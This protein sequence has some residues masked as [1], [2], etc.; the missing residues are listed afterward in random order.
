M[1]NI[2]ALLIGINNYPVKPL[3]GCINDVAAMKACLEKLYENLP[4]SRLHIKHL[5]D[6]GEEQPTRANIIKAFDFFQVA[7]PGDECLFYFSGHGS[8]TVA[9]LIFQSSSNELQSLVCIDSRSPGGLDLMDKELGFLIW[10]TTQTNKG[11]FF[12][13]I[14]DCC[15]SGT[16]TKSLQGIGGVT[17]RLL[18]GSLAHIPVNI[19]NYLGYGTQIDGIEAYDITE[20]CGQPYVRTATGNHYHLS[21][22]RD[23]Q[24]AKE[25]PINQGAVQ[26]AFTHCLIQRLYGNGGL[27][28]Y[29][30]LIDD[31]TVFVKNRVS[32]QSPSLNTYGGEGLSE[33][34]TFMGQST[35]APATAFELS[36]STKNGE[37]WNINGGALHGIH[38]GDEI[39]TSSGIRS[40]VVSAIGPE[41][42]AVRPDLAFGA[43]GQVYPVSI[44]RK[45]DERY[46]VSI[47]SGTG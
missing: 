45:A 32:E 27:V 40:T 42:S 20:R 7:K 15:H 17:E 23:Y 41:R 1:A 19:E 3:S 39:L 31:T 13:A 25:L 22:S 47:R 21:A 30:K 16:I 28:S 11:I 38:P 5:T 24:T 6:E 14:T 37:G 36:Y 33:Q 46:T 18:G 12:T 26:G 4:E 34:R 2:Y 8:S 9:P 35:A 29:R 44:Q 43:T 10:K